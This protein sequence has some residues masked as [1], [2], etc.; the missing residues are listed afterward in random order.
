MK[1]GMSVSKSLKI[2]MLLISWH[3]NPS[4]LCSKGVVVG[5][6]QQVK[7]TKIMS[8]IHMRIDTY[9]YC[10]LDTALTGIC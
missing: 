8:L 6:I 3:R 9:A 5:H 4:V 2:G 7:F 1:H 10:V